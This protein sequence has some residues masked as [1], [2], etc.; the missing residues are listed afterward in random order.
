MARFELP[1]LSNQQLLAVRPY[2]R[3]ASGGVAA[4]AKQPKI[5][6]LVALF[7]LEIFGFI[8]KMALKK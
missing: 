3:R 7:P 1:M 8:G 5:S 6:S 2:K 4:L